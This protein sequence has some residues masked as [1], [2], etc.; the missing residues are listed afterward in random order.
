MF[1]SSILL[2]KKLW[3]LQNKCLGMCTDL[4]NT[5]LVLQSDPNLPSLLAMTHLK[6]WHFNY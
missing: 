1:P 2:C 5:L 3:K 6:L 4:E